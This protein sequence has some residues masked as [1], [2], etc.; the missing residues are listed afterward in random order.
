MGRL[1][2]N[3]TYT[4][5]AELIKGF[6]LRELWAP[7]VDKN[8]WTLSGNI[9]NVFFPGINM[10]EQ[11][12]DPC[13]FLDGQSWSILAL[14]PE[15]PV[16]KTDGMTTTLSIALDH[17]IQTM[18][19]TGA[20][21]FLGTGYT[22]TGIDGFKENDGHV[23]CESK[24]GNLVWS[25]GSE[26]V[27]AAL[28]SIGS[29]KSIRDANYYHVETASYMMANGGV[30]YSTLPANPSDPNWNWTDTNSIAGTAWFYFNEPSIRLNPFQPWNWPAGCNHPGKICLP[31]ILK[32]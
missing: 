3:N 21:I 26:G 30:P 15:T 10:E 23:R 13:I 14:G 5:R 8:K 29:T 6:L 4:Q 12:I 24:V 16:R 19:V 28:Y 32:N 25:E 31:V 22:V 2:G 7:H 17:V 9:K 18:R 1:T 27:I 20:T 11:A